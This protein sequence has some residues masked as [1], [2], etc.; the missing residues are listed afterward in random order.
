MKCRVEHRDGGNPSLCSLTNKMSRRIESK[1]LAKSTKHTK[2]LRDFG[3]EFSREF[4]ASNSNVAADTVEC[5]L[6]KPN[7]KLG[8]RL[9]FSAYVKIRWAIVEVKILRKG[10]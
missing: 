10:F 5:F 4:A 2:V 9:L 1:H 7:L 6:R 3:R 8:N